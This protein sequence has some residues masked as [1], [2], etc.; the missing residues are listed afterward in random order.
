MKHPPAW[1]LKAALTVGTGLWL[2][3]CDPAGN[4]ASQPTAQRTAADHRSDPSVLATARYYAQ[5]LTQ[6]TPPARD[7]LLRY[8]GQSFQPD[9]LPGRYL[10]R[11]RAY[12]I[13]VQPDSLAPAVTI[14][15]AERTQLYH[16]LPAASPRLAPGVHLDPTPRP[17]NPVLAVQPQELTAAF[18][19]WEG[20]VYIR[21]EEPV[22]PEMHASTL[23]YQNPATGGQCQLF[24]Q[25]K[26]APSAVSNAVHEVKLTRI[27]R[28]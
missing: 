7:Q 15:P 4:P 23:H 12:S 21:E 22:Q 2:P 17:T 8:Q 28:P 18:G 24:V 27:A 19:P 20:D 3:G 5:L 14:E 6:A 9:I 1:L 26:N 10:L 25:L 13:I 11:L 16:P